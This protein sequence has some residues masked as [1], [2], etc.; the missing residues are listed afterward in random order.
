MFADPPVWRDT[1][2][3][4]TMTPTDERLSRDWGSNFD[5]TMDFPEHCSPYVYPLPT[6]HECSP[7]H[8]TLEL[9]TA[10][11]AMFGMALYHMGSLIQSDKRL[12]L[13]GGPNEPYDW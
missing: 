13:P 8:S 3:T 6:A 11:Y 5:S 2:S 12:A 9:S 7:V 4:E 10:F 1:R